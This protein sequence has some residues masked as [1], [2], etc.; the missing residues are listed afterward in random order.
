[1]KAIWHGIVYS[2]GWSVKCCW[3][4]PSPPLNHCKASHVQ[5]GVLL[6]DDC[7]L[8][9]HETPAVAEARQMLGAT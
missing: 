7:V 5:Q 1:M 3:A 4:S 8:V 2:G 6:V 9:Q